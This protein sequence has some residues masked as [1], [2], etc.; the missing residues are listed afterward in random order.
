[1]P[2]SAISL[3]VKRGCLGPV[4]G[5]GPES[6]LLWPDGLGHAEKV[7][8]LG[9]LTGPNLALLVTVSLREAAGR[10][11]E[12]PGWVFWPAIRRIFRDGDTP[13]E[14]YT[15]A[16]RR[17]SE[18]AERRAA[19]EQADVKTGPCLVWC[20]PPSSMPKWI[21]PTEALG[22]IRSRPGRWALVYRTDRRVAIEAASKVRTGKLKFWLPPEEWD[23]KAA[24]I[25]RQTFGIWL[26]LER[27]RTEV[28]VEVD[29]RQAAAEPEDAELKRVS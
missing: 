21:P 25:E 7:D 20:D 10:W 23:S 8:R 28:A 22:E 29:R 17:M 13:D 16:R 26:K 19:R 11:G 9:H 1:M 14:A 4:L 15:W 27:R 6:S 18:V 2:T 3:D 5:R 12:L 24:A